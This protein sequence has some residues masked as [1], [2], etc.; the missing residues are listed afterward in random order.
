MKEL[1]KIQQIAFLKNLEKAYTEGIY[2]DTPANRKLGRVGMTYT[3]YAEKIK[4]DNEKKEDKNNKDNYEKEYLNIIE[5]KKGIFN[6]DR[7][8]EYKESKQYLDSVKDKLTEEEYKKFLN[9]LEEAAASG[10]ELKL[11]KTNSRGREGK[12][13]R[14]PYK[15]S[16]YNYE[17][18]KI[19]DYVDNLEYERNRQKNEDIEDRAWKEV[20]KLRD[21]QEDKEQKDRLLS[22][23][24][25]GKYIDNPL[26]RALGIVGKE[27]KGIYYDLD[28]PDETGKKKREPYYTDRFYEPTPH[29]DFIK[30]LAKE[31]NP[32]L[33]EK[34]PKYN[35]NLNQFRGIYDEML[36]SYYFYGDCPYTIEDL[37]MPFVGHNSP[38]WKEWYLK[39]T[40]R[41]EDIKNK[42]EKMYEE[43]SQ[44]YKELKEKLIQSF[45]NKK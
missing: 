21:E 34:S 5:K 45:K 11:I 16:K 32:N 20:N 8:E 27:D 23:I 36:R 4:K 42:H 15:K 38:K 35:D 41:R 44:K 2:A 18:V 39:Y 17:K 6:K 13:E 29:N 19:Q 14:V 28:I 9:N 25:D 3:A 31:I 26:N 33:N 12:Y 7:L 37:K 40:K 24:K 1:G 43:K 22:L 30:K 10:E